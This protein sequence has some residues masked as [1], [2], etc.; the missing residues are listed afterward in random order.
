MV[1]IDLDTKS[2]ISTVIGT[3]IP[4]PVGT[5]KSCK[6]TDPLKMGCISGI[7]DTYIV[8]GAFFLI[9]MMKKK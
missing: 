7:P 4:P 9:M 2:C 5:G 6:D 8:A 1:Y 3:G